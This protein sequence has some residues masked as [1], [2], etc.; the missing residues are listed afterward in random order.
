VTRRM[1]TDAVLA[2]AGDALFA[3]QQIG[4]A[5]DDTEAVLQVAAGWVEIYD[6]IA[7]GDKAL[8][9]PTVGFGIRSNDADEGESRPGVHPQHG[10]L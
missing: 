4:E 5:A 9:R 8:S 6:R 10:E 2:Y 1:D 3:A 7:Y